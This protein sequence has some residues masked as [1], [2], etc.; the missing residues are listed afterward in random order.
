MRTRRFV[1]TGILLAVSGI[2]SGACLKPADPRFREKAIRN[3]KFSGFIA[4]DFFQVIVTVDP[5]TAEIPIREKRKECLRRSVPL[6]N[7]LTI[8]LLL[9]ETKDG[10]N[11]RFRGINNIYK[12]Y[13]GV[14][15]NQATPS[16]MS[17]LMGAQ[18]EPTGPVASAVS[19][20]PRNL[21]K[22]SYN[23]SAYIHNKKLD[24]LQ[25]EYAWFLDSFQLYKE[26]YSDP[27]SCVFIYRVAKKGLLEKVE[28]TNLS[29]NW[30]E[31]E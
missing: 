2:A 29:I 3:E 13:T 12:S 6:R 27:D 26:D 21:P 30:K 1:W 4:R 15:Q 17:A 18:A 23:S 5:T 8:P 19:R 28:E 31:F 14:S 10:E 22:G 24:F 20:T 25:G 16:P 9:K 7:Q 11:D